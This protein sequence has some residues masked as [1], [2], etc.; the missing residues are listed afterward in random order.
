MSA[1]LTALLPALLFWYDFR[2]ELT[3]FG[4][5]CSPAPLIPVRTADTIPLTDGAPAAMISGRSPEGRANAVLPAGAEPRPS[6]IFA[7]G[8]C[9][10]S[11]VPGPLPRLL[12]LGFPLPPSGTR[13]SASG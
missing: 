3:S 10:A 2:P 12:P 13:G 8:Q 4:T 5:Y 11:C 6:T 7:A 9:C 1:A